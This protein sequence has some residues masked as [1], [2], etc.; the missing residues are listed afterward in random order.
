MGSEINVLCYRQ[1]ILKKHGSTVPKTYMQILQTARKLK[2]AEPK[3]IP[4]LARGELSWDSI[5]PG[6]LSGFNA[7]GG[8]D[9]DDQL[10]PAMNSAAGV[11]FTDFFMRIF[12]KRRDRRRGVGRDTGSST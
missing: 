4:F 12:L 3:M 6:Y 1:D 11:E 2:S 10:K 7:Y 5:H 9:F 8:R